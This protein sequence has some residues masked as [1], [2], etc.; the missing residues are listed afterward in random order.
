MNA[1]ENMKA[2]RRWLLAAP[3]K[4]PHY[5]D[6][7]KRRGK[8]DSPEDIACLA[9]YEG[10]KA[11]LALCGPG[12]HLGFA[13]GPDGNGGFWQ[14]EDF[15]DIDG[16]VL[17]WITV[18][19]PG[20]VEKSPSGNGVHAIGYGRSFR[21]LG[22]NG[23][24][25]EAYCSGRY[26]TVTGK[27]IRD[28]G[29]VCLADHVEGVLVPVHAKSR[30]AVGSE[31]SAAGKIVTTSPQTVADLRSALNFMRSDNYGLWIEIG[32]GLK[33]LG[34]VGRG[35]WMDWSATSGKFDPPEAAGKWDT[36]SPTETSY[37]AVFAKAQALGWINPA[38]NAA[39][40]GSARSQREKSTGRRSL[41]L[42]SLDNVEMRSI[43]WLWLGWIAKGYIT[44]I[45]GETGAGKSTVLADITARVTTGASW[46]G[47]SQQAVRAP[48]RVLWLGS[49][50][51]TAEM[52]VP[53]MVACGADC[54]RIVEITGVE[55][56]GQRSTFS[57]QDD[58]EAVADWLEFY[59]GEGDPFTML[60]IDPVTSYLP[61][62]RLRKV[63]LNDA[64]QLRSILEPWLHLAQKFDLAIVCV[65][66]LAKDTKRSM[67]HR[68]LGS[69]AFVQ[70]CRSLLVVTDLPTGEPSA[71]HHYKALLQAKNNLP[72]SPAGGW[73]FKTEKVEVGT[74]ARN[75]KPISATVPR[76]E[77]LD[78]AL[79]HH[80]V[81]GNSR[82]PVSTNVLPFVKWLQQQFAQGNE[83]QPVNVMLA[84]AL[85]EKIVSKGWWEKNSRRYLEKANLGG[86][87]HC[88][89]APS[90]LETRQGGGKW[91]NWADWGE[92]GEVP[93]DQSDHYPPP[94]PPSAVSSRVLDDDGEPML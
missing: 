1:F 66:H 10:A 6:G 82:G 71:G 39:Q 30:R 90:M 19:L 20:Y 7:S 32:H 14:G 22:S 83:W 40:S 36:F 86:E 24:G 57:M 60:V 17:E 54:S 45:A 43:D 69:T 75:G 23:S 38:S 3:D 94:P 50:D 88:R 2:A 11:A 8:L 61:G 48:G 92:V 80:N 64:G 55:C 13:L 73:R 26:F 35:L 21:T 85:K 81:A 51:N 68:V 49:E 5:L 56:S 18:D 41:R 67:L 34:D 33:E 12:W 63:D 53:R 46:P 87:W 16:N 76:W 84:R 44:L 89:L 93:T 9:S 65:T 62:A 4:A 29:L 15:D 37:Q 78:P 25:I 91:S 74:D 47:E 31:R 79:T 59:Q 72:D 58:L 70:T 42:N 28:E 77:E 27:M 52:T